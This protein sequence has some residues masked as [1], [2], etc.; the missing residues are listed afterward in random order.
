MGIKVK[1]FHSCA[2]HCLV[3]LLIAK[4]IML[5][6]L[7]NTLWKVPGEMDSLWFILTHDSRK[8]PGACVDWIEL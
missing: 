8:N 7:W 3:L 1:Y 6:N 5:Q 4:S 2:K